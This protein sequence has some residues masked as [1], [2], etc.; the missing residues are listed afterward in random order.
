MKPCTQ[1]KMVDKVMLIK[2]IW[3]HYV[4]CALHVELEQLR[5][6]LLETLEIETFAR[7]Y[8]KEFYGYLIG[9]TTFDV[10]PNYILDCFMIRYS[11]EGSNDR[12]LEEAI[13]MHWTEYVMECESKIQHYNCDC[14]LENR[15]YGYKY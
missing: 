8:P 7:S 11:D 9:S 2:S 4:F 15:P 14:I 12:T 5:K 6:G 10:T 1:L 3:L 13:V